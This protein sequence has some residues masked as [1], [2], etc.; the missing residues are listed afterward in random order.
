MEALY[1]IEMEPD[2]R[3]WLEL[4]TDRHHRKVEEYAELLAGLG[5]STPMPFARP[6]RDGVYELR[7]TLDG[8]DTRITYWFAP[9]RRYDRAKDGDAK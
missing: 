9:D 4:L 7:P 6:L 3:A 2:V 8:Q 5:A 1:T